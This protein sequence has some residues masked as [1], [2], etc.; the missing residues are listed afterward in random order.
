M[1]MARALLLVAFLASAASM[2][3]TPVQ[4]VLQM[5]SEMK[6]KGEKMMEQE[7]KTMAEYTE[8]VD[9][10]TTEL[11]YEKKTDESTIDKLSAFI[12]KA[13]DKV[14]RLGEEIQA[15]DDEIASL[16][17]EKSGATQV[18]NAE[19]EEYVKVSTDYGESVDALDRAIDTLA[20]QGY[21]RA[22]AAVMLQRMAKDSAGM[23][24]VLAAFLQ[25][26]GKSADN[27]APAVDAY[28]FQSSSIVELMEQ[29]YKKFKNELA[30]VESEES[31]KAHYYDLEMLHLSD[32]IT[33][34]KQDREEKAATKATT[35]AKSAKAKENLR[36]TKQDLAEDQQFLR[37]M[38]VEFEAKKATFEANQEVRKS[39][40]EALSKAIEIIS[41]P[42]VS[43]SYG[44]RINLVQLSARPVALI[45]T[46]SASKRI[47][48]RQRAAEFLQKRAAA[49]NSKILTMMATNIAGNP[50]AKVV[51]MIE[52]LLAKLKEEAAAEADHKE[53][54][55]KELKAN[56][57]KRD[58]QTTDFNKLTAQ[59]EEKTEQIATMG[60]DIA[61][62][63]QEQADLTKAMT[64]ATEQRTKEKRE[65]EEAIADAI[66]GSTAVRKALV[67]LREF[68]ASQESF[69]QQ[70]PEMKEYKGMASGGIVGM[71]EVVETDFVRLETETKAAEAQAASAYAQFMKDAKADSLMKHNKEVKLKLEKDQAEFENS[72]LKKDLDLTTEQLGKANEYYEYLKPECLEVHVNYEDRVARR[73][74]EIAALKEAYEILDSKSG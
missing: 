53:W 28:E 41:S 22:Q 50:F 71:L 43:A 20:A 10:K 59:I 61:T 36:E 14:R 2:S 51:Q 26:T 52:D 13:D 42:D 48:L 69:A 32:T 73:K 47:A 63:I 29:L 60:K 67:I 66:A 39:E 17:S 9:D 33:K 72:N 44:E 70:V 4:Q 40:L 6:A 54:C 19:H 27:G 25:Q 7:Q 5:M 11:G 58:R 65:N 38:T 56:K 8:W 64:E 62:L 3:I 57:L 24:R 18:R 16:E 31:E 45:Q 55:D 49:L 68:Y 12:A 46:R 74:E 35:A 30:D 1:K 37:D 21:D 15:L 34:S 23:R